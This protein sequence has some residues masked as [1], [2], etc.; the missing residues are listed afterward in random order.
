MELDRILA[1]YAKRR[2]KGLYDSRLDDLI[3]ESD[4]PGVNVVETWP[5]DFTTKVPN[6]IKQGFENATK[7]LA[8]ADHPN[9]AYFEDIDVIASEGQ[10]FVVVKSRLAL[11]QTAAAH[12]NGNGNG[13]GK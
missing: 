9:H 10:V 11:A 13:N 3:N 2:V 4:E 12:T 8:L 5:A 7:R 1:L 6:T